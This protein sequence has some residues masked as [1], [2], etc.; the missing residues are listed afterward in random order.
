[1][2]TPR[3]VESRI[4]PAAG[5]RS[6]EVAVK[7]AEIEAV[8]DLVRDA[9]QGLTAELLGHQSSPGRNTLGMLIAHIAVAET[10]LG[11]VGLVGDPS[12]HVQDVLGIRE[13]DDG[14]PLPADGTPPAVLTG[15][16]LAFF[17]DL[18]SRAEAHTRSACEPLTDEILG[19]EIVRPPRPDGTQRVFDRRWILLHMVEHA[20]SHLGQIRNMRAGL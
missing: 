6:R 7:V 12:G 17:L 11:Q 19:H 10:H 15:R 9:V 16:D 18:L 5:Y 3:R 20:A 8:H 2:S 4:V 14:L 1:V 13:D